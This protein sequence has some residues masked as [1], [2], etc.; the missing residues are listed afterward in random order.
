MKLKK[1]KLNLKYYMNQIENCIRVTKGRKTNESE[2]MLAMCMRHRTKWLVMKWEMVAWV[3]MHRI[4]NLLT[5]HQT[6]KKKWS[7]HN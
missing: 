2:A 7:E 3:A 4:W 6:N 5:K 1:G